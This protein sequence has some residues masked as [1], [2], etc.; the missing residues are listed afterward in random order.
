MRPLKLIMSAFGPYAERTEID[1]TRLGEHGLY[2]ITGDT[3]AG[4]TTIF[5]AIVFALYGE[6]SGVVRESGMFRSKYAKDNVPTFV[7]LTFD[8]QGKIYVVNRNPEYLRPKGRGTG[9]TLQKGD[10]VL[11]FPDGRQPVT[12]TREVTRAVEELIGLDC[13][14]FTQIAMIAQGDFQKLLLAGTAER[15]EIFRKIFHTGLY[16]EVQFRLKDAVKSRWKEYDEIRR[17][18]SQY[19]AGVSCGDDLEMQAELDSLKK[20]KFEG[21]VGRGLEILEALLRDEAAGLRELDG[22]AGELESRIQKED[23]LLGTIEQNR[24]MRAELEQ[25]RDALEKRLPELDK[26][27]KAWVDAQKAAIICEELSDQIRT[28]KEHLGQY[29]LLSDQQV[30]QIQKNREI[31][32]MDREKTLAAEVCQELSVRIAGQKAVLEQYQSVG[33]ERERMLHQEEMLKQKRADIQQ[34]I[35][36]LEQMKKT[37]EMKQKDYRDSCA[38]RDQQRLLYERMEQLFFDAQA[39]MLAEHLE[40]GQLC[41]VCGSVHHPKLA[42]L[43][44]EVPDKQVL[45]RSKRELERLDANVQQLSAQ[46][47]MLRETYQKDGGSLEEMQQMIPQLDQQLERI[48]QRLE[49]NQQQLK[50]KYVLENAI[51]KQEEDLRKQEQVIRQAELALARLQLELEHLEAEISRLQDMLGSRPREELERQVE[52]WQR[53]KRQ[54]E[55]EEQICHQHWQQVN[56]QVTELQSAIKALASQTEQMPELDREE[57][58]VRKDQWTKQKQ[59]IARQKNELFAAFQN[60][61]GIY[62]SVRDKEK[63]MIAVE[64]EYI[65]IKSLSDTANGGLN[66]KRKIELETYIQM[67]YFDRIIRRANLRLMT[68]SGGQYELKRQ[69]DGENKKEKTGMELNVIDHYNGTERSV[70][71]LSGGESFQASLSLAL[72]LSDEI[73]SYAGGIRLDTMFVDEGFGSLDE[74]SLNQAMHALQGLAE[75]RRLVGIISHV[76]ELKERIDNKII[77]TKCRSRDGVGSKAEVVGLLPDLQ[78]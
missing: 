9:M 3:G 37:I 33:E 70:K 18:I 15:G 26:A 40:E 55:Q 56:Q 24:R 63:D 69:E 4:K 20:V 30:L 23:Q 13:R 17:S 47:G 35:A 60:N 64:Q 57:I 54:L 41:P 62:D 49:E 73:Q 29:Q 43:P 75:G 7:E 67:S 11:T 25:N 77:V 39:G 16:Q 21:K 5:D 76:A 68:M 36:E 12:K 65:W 46:L 6:A 19:L 38:K 50:E 71:T 28:G 78:G 74:E 22:Q 51:P 59:Q 52:T 48:R 27:Q 2:L 14:Q 72:G 8:Y 66:G 45:D 58:S 61:R 42:V 32:Q 53:Q 34:D 44:Q 10:A 31:A 1:F